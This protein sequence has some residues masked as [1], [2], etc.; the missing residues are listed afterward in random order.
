MSGT[1]A[2][3]TI[4]VRDQAWKEFQKSFQKYQEAV[5]HSGTAWSKVQASFAAHKKQLASMPATWGS[6]GKAMNAAV[7]P[8]VRIAASVSVMNSRLK[9]APT[10]MGKM[11]VIAQSVVGVVDKIAKGAFS[12]AKNIGK[13]TLSLLK[14]GGLAS[15]FSGLLGGVGLFGIDRLANSAS[16]IRRESQGLGV[17]PGELQAA[18]INFGKFTDVDSTLENV[19]NARSDVSKRWVF[20]ALGVNPDRGSNVDVFADSLKAAKHAFEQSGM[21]Q[22]GAEAH[23]LTE[24]FSMDDL[25][26]LHAMT[27]QEIDDSVRKQQADKQALDV[28]DQ[29]LRGW[30]SLKIQLDRAGTQI[31]NVLITKLSSLSDPLSSLSGAVVDAITMFANDKDLPG[32]IQTLGDKIREFAT[33]LTSDQFKSDME[34]FA[35]K[36]K[37]VASGLGDLFDWIYSKLKFLGII[38]EPT[39]STQPNATGQT[40]QSK[41]ASGWGSLTPT[42]IDNLA[43]KVRNLADDQPNYFP[44]IEKRNKLPAG[45]LEKIQRIEFS[46]KDLSKAVSPKGAKGPFQIM[47]STAKQYGLDDPFNLHDSAETAGKILGDLMKKYKGDFEKAAAAYNWGAGNVDKDLATNGD[48]WKSHLP[49]ETRD[50]IAMA[51]PSNSSTSTSG[52]V[53]PGGFHNRGLPPVLIEVRNNTGG[54]AIV[55][56]NALAQ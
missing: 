55:T 22:Q 56:T 51:S 3:V 36:V 9:D 41:E 27:D 32:Y 52:P 50:Y 2:I 12:I 14:W 15:I 1:R 6:I 17:S 35:E 25:R 54:S 24:L 5:A 29:T 19:A 7:Q 4:D 34:D 43:W 40:G 11:R 39:G 8:F 16:N 10:F 33:Y 18:R 38:K 45:S 37:K 53:M 21:T 26:R 47:E 30:Q 48:Q 49:K 31:E 28:S 20:S 46:G 13:A 44:D 23:G 42:S